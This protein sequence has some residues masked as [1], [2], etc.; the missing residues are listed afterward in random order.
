MTELHPE[1]NGSN[2]SVLT[3]IVW[4]SVDGHFETS[5]PFCS[6]KALIRS[7]CMFVSS[8]QV[9]SSSGYPVHLT[10]YWTLLRF[11]AR[12]I[13]FRTNCLTMNW[14]L[15]ESMAA[16]GSM[17]GIVHVG[18]GGGHLSAYSSTIGSPMLLSV[19]LICGSGAP[20]CYPS[21]FVPGRLPS[22]VRKRPSTFLPAL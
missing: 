7:S 8:S 21:S 2:W 22:R 12:R 9:F 17:S 20:Q 4:T 19:H 6:T 18:A 11:L 1:S 15:S 3:V 16:G 14:Q 10:R 5:R 13:R